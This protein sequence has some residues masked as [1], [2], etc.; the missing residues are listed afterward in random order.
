[1][2]RKECKEL[3][4]KVKFLEQSFDEL[5][6]PHERLIEAHEKLG[7]AHSKLEKAH[8]SLIE[9]VKKEEAKKEQVN[10]SC[11][12]RLTCDII[13]KS[14]YK[15]IVVA[16]TNPSC[17]TTTSTYTSPLSDG[18]TCDVSLMVENETI[19]KEV[20]ELTRALGNAYGGDACLLKCL[21]SQRFS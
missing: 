1:M 17:S 5:N 7:K 18:F 16:T 12:V 2:K 19:K 9:Q 8:S 13:D 20:N 15:P 3:R 14:F 21:G 4:K 11:D 10:V 6:A